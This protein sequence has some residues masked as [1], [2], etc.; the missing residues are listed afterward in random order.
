MFPDELGPA[1]SLRISVLLSDEELSA[2]IRL[3]RERRVTL[4][5]MMRLALREE[6]SRAGTAP[7]AREPES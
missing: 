7:A 2:L 1:P 5:A 6:L 3:S 4:A